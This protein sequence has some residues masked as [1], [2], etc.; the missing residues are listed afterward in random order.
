MAAAMVRVAGAAVDCCIAERFRSV[1]ND[2]SL[3]HF[4]FYNVFSKGNVVA[5][6][7][8]TKR[9]LE[10]TDDDCGRVIKI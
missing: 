10:I 5:H 1:T 9:P 3:S 7:A 6:Y 4:C 2:R 8:E